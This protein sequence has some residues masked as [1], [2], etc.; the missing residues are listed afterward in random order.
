MDAAAMGP[1]LGSELEPMTTI[2]RN[3]A[4][5]KGVHDDATARTLGYQRGPVPG[6]TTLAYVVD[7]LLD[8][9]GEDWTDGGD[10]SLAFTRP[11]FEGER[12]T[13]RAVV[14]EKKEEAS[15]LRVSL[16]VWAENEKGEKV[17][18]GTASGLLPAQG[19][20]VTR[21]AGR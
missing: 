21:P 12:V 15:G 16:D 20:P 5:G 18:S 8:L 13:I 7:M 10:I 17:A 19:Q 9:F 6:C 1:D 11:L 3:T 14:R 2:A 4:Q